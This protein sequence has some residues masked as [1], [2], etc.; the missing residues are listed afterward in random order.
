MERALAVEA[1][2]PDWFTSQL[3]HFSAAKVSTWLHLFELL[4]PHL[5]SGR[6]GAYLT[7]LLRGPDDTHTLK[8]LVWLPVLS[9]CPPCL[10]IPLLS[11]PFSD[12]EFGARIDGWN[13]P[14]TACLE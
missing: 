9:N 2:R 4:S 3:F 5:K 7:G 12:F 14:H 1:G 8:W 13:D 10:S 6:R 11:P